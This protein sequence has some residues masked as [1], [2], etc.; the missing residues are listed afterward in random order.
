[1]ILQH[2]KKKG[3]GPNSSTK[4]VFSAA[5]ILCVPP[6]QHGVWLLREEC[7]VQ[8]KA[9]VVHH[10]GDAVIRGRRAGGGRGDSSGAIYHLGTTRGAG[11]LGPLGTTET[12]TSMRLAQ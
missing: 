2:K 1:M 11:L 7:R 8:H 12:K 5:L 6:A 10:E 4:L 3:F 9:S